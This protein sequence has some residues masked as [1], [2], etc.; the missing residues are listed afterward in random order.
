M[1]NT[2]TGAA[3]TIHAFLANGSPGGMIDLGSLGGTSSTARGINATG[4]VV[5]YS[6]TTKDAATHAFVSNGSPGGMT[7]LNTL[8]RKGG[9]GWVLIWA[10]GIN[11]NGLIV[12]Y[13]T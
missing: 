10:T 8:V 11:D 1:S 7:D 4:Q 6:N 2:T 12:G 13:G 5:G 3:A 9:A